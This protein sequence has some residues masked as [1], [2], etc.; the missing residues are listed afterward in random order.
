MV[1]QKGRKGGQERGKG[2]EVEQEGKEKE[3]SDGE[4]DSGHEMRKEGKI[5]KGRK[6][7]RLFSTIR[8][9]ASAHQIKRIFLNIQH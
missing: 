6:E 4:K 3:R 9:E 8:Q 5:N 1:G 7:G 2:N